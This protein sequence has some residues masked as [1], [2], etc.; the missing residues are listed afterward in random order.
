MEDLSILEWHPV[1][2]GRPKGKKKQKLTSLSL[3]HCLGYQSPSGGVGTPAFASLVL[4]SLGLDYIWFTIFLDFCRL[5][6]MG[7]SI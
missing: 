4:T 7:L 2:Y 1:M 5:Q 6:I 3:T